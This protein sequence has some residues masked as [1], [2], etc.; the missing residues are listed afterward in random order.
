MEYRRTGRGDPSQWLS[1]IK[2]FADSSP[3]FCD[4]ATVEH[5]DA[6][7]Y[8]NNCALSLEALKRSIVGRNDE[9]VTDAMTG[10]YKTCEAFFGIQLKAAKDD[11]GQPRPSVHTIYEDE[12]RDC[13]PGIASAAHSAAIVPLMPAVAHPRLS[14]S[15]ADVRRMS[16]AASASVVGS[17]P[18]VMRRPAAAA[19]SSAVDAPADL[20]EWTAAEQEVWRTGYVI[21]MKFGRGSPAW[22]YKIP[23][24]HGVKF[25]APRAR[26]ACRIAV[27]RRIAGSL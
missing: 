25:C 3:P 5:V 9:P 12:D 15:T 10:S 1:A 11:H 4:G 21:F 17:T 18:N 2:A 16:A 27:E 6:D 26:E 19:S 22:W 7:T 14:S 20:A 8:L 23:G 24:A 13:D